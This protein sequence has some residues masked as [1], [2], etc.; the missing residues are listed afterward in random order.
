MCLC[1]GIPFDH[2]IQLGL[3]VSSDKLA[4]TTDSSCIIAYQNIC[5]YIYLFIFLFVFQMFLLSYSNHMRAKYPV[6][7]IICRK[8]FHGRQKDFTTSSIQLWRTLARKKAQLLPFLTQLVL[9]RLVHQLKTLQHSLLFFCLLQQQTPFRG[10]QYPLTIKSYV[11]L[12]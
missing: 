7:W 1:C 10:P 2:Q 12:K 5:L 11:L 9:G 6:H 4:Y 8:R 3:A